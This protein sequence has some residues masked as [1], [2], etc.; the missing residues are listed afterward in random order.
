MKREL[1][2]KIMKKL[3]IVIAALYYTDR[4]PKEQIENGKGPP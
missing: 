4:F 3:D 2:K 1:F